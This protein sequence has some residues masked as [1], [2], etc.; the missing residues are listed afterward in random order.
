MGY[1][2]PIIRVSQSIQGRLTYGLFD[3]MSVS[4]VMMSKDTLHPQS[5][6]AAR[7]RRS[8]PTLV[9]LRFCERVLRYQ[10]RGCKTGPG[11][12]LFNM[13][14][15]RALIHSLGCVDT[16]VR[17]SVGGYRLV[18]L[19]ST[20]GERSHAPMCRIRDVSGQVCKVHH[21][22]KN[23]RGTSAVWIARHLVGRPSASRSA[24]SVKR[25][26][27]ITSSRPCKICNG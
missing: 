24:S 14:E 19:N 22:L 12:I 17:C 20:F 27:K 5:S 9:R 15:K 6:R 16:L 2:G 8:Y 21:S 25:E 3:R 13:L 4:I 11:A 10:T 18:C 1:A 23:S 26:W 7:I